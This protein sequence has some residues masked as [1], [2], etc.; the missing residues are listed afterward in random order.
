MHPL[1]PGCSLPLQRHPT[2]NFARQVLEPLAGIGGMRAGLAHRWPCARAKFMM[3]VLNGV[4]AVRA[5]PWGA[6][7]GAA[8]AFTKK[9]VMLCQALWTQRVAAGLEGAHDGDSHEDDSD[10]GEAEAHDAARG[11]AA[12]RH[13]AY[14]ARHAQAF[15]AQVRAGSTRNT[16]L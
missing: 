11:S 4:L 1:P 14:R 16:A 2:R 15:G 7:Y 8:C 5:L 3:E 6:R 9:E 12:S 10:G 13:D